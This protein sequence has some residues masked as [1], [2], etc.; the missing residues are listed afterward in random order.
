[1]SPVL[2]SPVMVPVKSSAAWA[3]SAV[4]WSA[5]AVAALVLV[6]A[7]DSPVLAQDYEGARL[8]GLADAQRA[9][10][11]GNDA[12]FV[13]PA[14]LAFTPTYE[15]ELGYADDLRESDRRL[16]L[17]I[18]DGQSGPIAGAIALTYGLFR[19]P[20]FAS[21][22]YRL[23][24]LRLDI[25][26]AFQLAQGFAFGGS[27]RFADYRLLFG[28]EEIEN[29][30]SSGFAFD[31][32]SQWQL[33][34][35]L[36]LGVTLQNLSNTNQ[37]DLPRAWGAGLG[38]R[39]GALLLEVDVDHAWEVRDPIYSLAAGYVF[40]ERFPIR[41]GVSYLQGSEEVAISV[42]AGL[43]VERIGLDLAYRQIVDP[44]RSASDADERLFVLS[45]RIR[46]F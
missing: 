41:A 6:G 17:S 15:V 28:E 33:G 24:G 1:M 46:V 30:G 5:G 34:G 45:F 27:V 21:G 18:A 20:L 29:G 31:L 32:G 26:A 16:N 7:L 11:V 9:L 40:G 14:G 44:R 39:T 35:G 3:A 22:D 37:P 12:I 43:A 2:T 8:L 13:N 42:G 23:E 10:A 38:W 36:S 25:A 4:R 19:P